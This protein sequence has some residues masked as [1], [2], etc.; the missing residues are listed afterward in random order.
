M[1]ELNE[2]Q[3]IRKNKLKIKQIQNF[4]FGSGLVIGCN[5]GYKCGDECKR[6]QGGQE[7]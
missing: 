3:V 1:T 5:I 7:N 6:C 4:D 2:N